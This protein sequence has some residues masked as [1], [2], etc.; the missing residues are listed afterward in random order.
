MGLMDIF[1]R[2]VTKP[3]NIEERKISLNDLGFFN[4]SS[5]NNSKAM[6]LSAVYC[7]TQQISNAVSVLPMQVVM[8]KDGKKRKVDHSLNN[9]LNIK[10]CE[11]FSH[12]SMMKM[13]IESLLLKGNAYAL[14]VRNADLSIKSLEYL[15]PDNVQPTMGNDGRIK[16]LVNGLKEAVDSVNMIHLYLHLD[17][18]YRGISVIRYATSSLDGIWA[19]EK[20]ANNFFKSGGN[21]NGVITSQAPM[22]NDQK[23]QVRDSW[24]TF[25][26]EGVH[27]AVLPQGLDYKPIAIDPDDASLLDSRKYGNLEIARW[28][29]IPPSKLFVL[30]Q[31]S[32]NSMEF[33]QLTFLSDTILPITTLIENEL[34][35][36]LFKPSEI[37][38][39]AIDF[40]FTAILETDKKSQAQYYNSMISNG[41]LS[42]NEVR[43][44]LGFEP[45]TDEEG[46][47]AHFIQISYG[48]VANVASGAYIK[49]NAQSQNQ[50]IDN[51]VKDKEK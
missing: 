1:K 28:F 47:N 9:L 7:A 46:G 17:E 26:Q 4:G 39:L 50:N 45:I 6:K 38:K 36:K 31:E 27:V 18:T 49:Q 32:Y 33:A 13:M 8:I 23:Q 14:I 20:N 44:K 25:S 5:Y 2:N 34:N 37:G 21:V 43:D 30:D 35:T 3:G 12:F 40:D 51:K 48:S 11:R 19:T 16:Y 29:N 10:P 24:G 42:I 15:D 41:V 22:T